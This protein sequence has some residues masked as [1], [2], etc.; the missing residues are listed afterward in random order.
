[1]CKIDHKI[2]LIIRVEH[3]PRLLCLGLFII[4]AGI[5]ICVEENI[6]IKHGHQTRLT[7]M[8]IHVHYMDLELEVTSRQRLADALTSVISRISSIFK[9]FSSNDPLLLKRKGG[10]L[11]QWTHGK[12][13]NRC[14][15]YD[16]KYPAIGEEC[17]KIKI[18][19]AHLSELSVWGE[20]GEEPLDVRYPR[21]EGLR[22]TDFVLYVQAVSSSDCTKDGSILAHA[23]Y[24]YQD[25]RGR[26]VAG[27]TNVCPQSMSRSTQDRVEMILLHE[28][29]HTMGFT[30]RLFED[31]RQCSIS[32]ELTGVCNVSDVRRSPIQTI[33]SRPCL[34]TLAVEREARQ[35]FNCTEGKFG[36]ALQNKGD[37]FSHWDGHQMYGS[38][39]TPNPGPPHLT[40]LDRMTLA[41]FE[42]SGWYEVDYSQADEYYWGKG[43]GCKLLSNPSVSQVCNLGE[44]GCHFLHRDKAVCKKLSAEDDY[45]SFVSE[46]GM[47]CWKENDTGS[48]L[49]LQLYSSQSLCFM[50][51]LTNQNSSQNMTGQCYLHRC[52]DG[53]LYVKVKNTEWTKCPY[54]EAIQVGMLTGVVLCP[55]KKDFICSKQENAPT[56]V[57]FSI[58]HDL[59]ASQTTGSFVFAS[60]V[61]PCVYINV[62]LMYCSYF[63]FLIK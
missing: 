9:V 1:M 6:P 57:P 26:P 21:G 49:T 7:A 55:T 48:A 24:C 17:N 43:K 15:Y 19:S 2:N 33:N 44:H 4:L 62:Y 38:I 61:G 41:V 16:R 60:S 12:N 51:N 31:F 46:P 13:K 63:L 53:S 58:S 32:D 54:G 22:D 45:T 35:H 34:V 40:F 20:A 28:L 25:E 30:K 52:H 8:R 29:L 56:P 5:C 27:Y 14:R 10:C 59:S 42:D 18:P 36:P 3:F 23:S 37:I 39:M 50:S 47:E 11:K